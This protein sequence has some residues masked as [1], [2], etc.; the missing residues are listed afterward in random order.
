M[1]KVLTDKRFFVRHHVTTG[2]IMRVRDSVQLPQAVVSRFAKNN[3]TGALVVKSST[4]LTKKKRTK[5]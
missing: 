3:S 1:S 5:K 2:D 4:R